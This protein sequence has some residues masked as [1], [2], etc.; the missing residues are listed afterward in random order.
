[1]AAAVGAGHDRRGLATVVLGELTRR[2][3]EDGL[4]HV[5]APL[6]PT[7]KH[8]YPIVP[9]DEYAGWTR[10]DGLSIDPWIRTHQRMGARV[11]TTAARST[12]GGTSRRTSGSSTVRRRRSG[13]ARCGGC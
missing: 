10:A 2:A 4:A 6:R 8:R 5:I 11:L 7:W 3:S 1:M 9:M 12:A 13:S